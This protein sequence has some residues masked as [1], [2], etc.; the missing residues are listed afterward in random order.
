M[1][2]HKEIDTKIQTLYVFTFLKGRPPRAFSQD[3]LH[4]KLQKSKNHNESNSSYHL[5]IWCFDL[6]PIMIPSF[7]KENWLEVE[8]CHHKIIGNMISIGFLWADD[9]LVYKV[10]DLI[11]KPS[12]N[13]PRYKSNIVLV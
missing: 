12:C 8:C 13:G 6:D 11:V 1:K 9:N 10:I 7:A 2:M 4:Y 3:P 5:I